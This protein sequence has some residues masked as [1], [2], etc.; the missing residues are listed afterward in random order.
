MIMISPRVRAQPTG[1]TVSGTTHWTAEKTKTG[2]KFQ[3]KMEE[4]KTI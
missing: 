2:E 4:V 3:G 1:K